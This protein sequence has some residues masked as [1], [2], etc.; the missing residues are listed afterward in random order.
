ML[1]FVYGTLKRGYGNN[2]LLVNS[3]FVREGTIR[4]KQLFQAGFPV[5]TEGLPNDVV[6]GEIWDISGE[7]QDATLRALDRLESEG[8]MYDREVV[9][10]EDGAKV[11]TYIGNDDYWNRFDGMR[12]CNVEMQEGVAHHSWDR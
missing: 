7:N 9:T 2:R 3:A 8:F 5:M 1:V 10:T 11:N 12:H 6:H 4:G